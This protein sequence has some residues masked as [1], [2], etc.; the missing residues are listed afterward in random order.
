M[1]FIFSSVWPCQPAATEAVTACSTYINIL[2]VPCCTGRG[3]RPNPVP[4]RGAICSCR[5]WPWWGRCSWRFPRRALM[6]LERHTPSSTVTRSEAAAALDV[7]QLASVLADRQSAAHYRGRHF[8]YV[9]R[10]G[11]RS[12]FPSC[13]SI[14]YANVPP[15]S[16]DEPSQ[17]HSAKRRRRPRRRP[18]ERGG[19]CR[20]Q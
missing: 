13:S 12:S 17:V 20:R 9:W 3:G 16:T 11:D 15:R 4:D 1:V 7:R 10:E 19:G 14:A 2:V 5:E 18:Q 8:G 6:H